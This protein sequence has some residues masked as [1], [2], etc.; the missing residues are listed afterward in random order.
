M[1]SSNHPGPGTQIRIFMH[2]LTKQV[3]VTLQLS[4]SKAIQGLAVDLT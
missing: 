2:V 1:S 4:S 3:G